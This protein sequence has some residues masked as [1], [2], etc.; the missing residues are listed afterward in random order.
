MLANLIKIEERVLKTLCDGSHTSKSGALE[1]LA[2]EERLRILEQTDVIS[3]DGLNQVLSGSQ[4]AEGNAEMVGI[5]EGVEK[6]LVERMDV[7]ESWEPVENERD[8]LAESLLCEL[9]L[10]GIEVYDG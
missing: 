10:A 6:I 9:D 8:L 1:L 5:V 7:L 3:G 2:L 4:L